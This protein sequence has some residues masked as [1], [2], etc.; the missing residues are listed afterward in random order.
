[1]TKRRTDAGPS[2]FG[3]RARLLAL[4]LPCILGLLALDSWDDY[5][6]LRGLVQDSYD[7]VMLESVRALQGSVVLAPDGSFA[8]D[9]AAPLVQR[10]FDATSPQGK[11]LHVGLSRR[12]AAPGDPPAHRVERTLLGD[13]D[14]PMPPTPGTPDTPA[15]ADAALPVWYD[16]DYRGQAMRLVALRSQVV[17]ANGQAFDLLVQAAESTGPRDLAEAASRRQQLFRDARMVFVVVLLVWLGVTW[18]LRP[19]ERLR[20]SVMRRKGLAPEP[21]DA[22][23]VPHEVAPLVDAVNENVASHRQLLDAQSQFLADASHQLRTP[24]AIMLT[25]A[26]VAL[27]EKDPKQLHDTLRAMVTQI[28]RSRRLCEQLLSMAHANDSV[29]P[30]AAQPV[31]DL[32]A[33][34]KDVV[35]QYLTLAHEK[36]QDLGWVDAR[37]ALDGSAMPAAGLPA[38]P[39][40]AS[41]PELHEILANLVHNAI[42][43]TPVGGHITVQ[44]G[45]AGG[46]ALAEVRDDGP[47]IPSGRRA[48]VFERFR[49][50]NAAH[51]K[52]PHGAGLGLA[53]ARA[54]ARRHGGD[55]SLE[56]AGAESAHGTGLRAILRV[57]LAAGD[58]R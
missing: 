58:T 34:A 52:G 15:A 32:N 30:T 33:I 49:Q 50:A 46:M 19:L 1:M 13:A 2:R 28:A 26:G 57:P 39:V 38:V 16:S 31:A 47:G 44:A 8:L 43:Y 7:R 18:S 17:D 53:I 22:S 11:H 20:R 29:E 5:R 41:A 25:Q 51:G 56:D 14:L 35:L 21:L 42:V 45:I 4:L 40:R 12:S 10:L 27:R 54:Y 36:D 55:I 37:E 9:A 48:E 6:A 24:L 23:G 3:I